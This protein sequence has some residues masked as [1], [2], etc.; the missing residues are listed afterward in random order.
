LVRHSIRRADADAALARDRWGQIA[1]K[2]LTLTLTL[3]H[4]ADG[5][6]EGKQLRRPERLEYAGLFLGQQPS[7]A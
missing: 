3:S 1:E 7:G 5:A 6:G 4:A 2:A